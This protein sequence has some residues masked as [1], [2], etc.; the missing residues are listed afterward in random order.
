MNKILVFLRGNV[1]TLLCVSLLIGATAVAWRLLATPLDPYMRAEYAVLKGNP[2]YKD[3]IG[4]HAG[5]FDWQEYDY[6]APPPMPDGTT[7]V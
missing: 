7:T 1:L 3:I 2:E 5:N 4:F 6:P